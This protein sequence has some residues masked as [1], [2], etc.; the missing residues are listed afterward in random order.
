MT[1][2][3]LSTILDGKHLSDGDTIVFILTVDGMIGSGTV[4]QDFFDQ[5][6][7]NHQFYYQLQVD[8][9]ET[10]Y[11]DDDE[12]LFKNNNCINYDP[13]S[14]GDYTFVMPLNLI[15]D[16]KDYKNLQLF[17]DC[18]EGTDDNEFV[19]DSSIKYSIFPAVQKAFVFGVGKNWG[20]D[21]NTN[22]DAPDYRYE[23]NNVL[24]DASGTPLDLKGG[25]KVEVILQGKIRTYSNDAF[26]RLDDSTTFTAELYDNAYYEESSFHALSIDK[27]DGDV[28]NTA[29]VKQ[30]TIGS[31]GGLASYGAFVFSPIAEP[32]ISKTDANFKNDFR[33]QCH[34]PCNNPE[35]LLVVTDYFFTNQVTN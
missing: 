33:F 30:L 29:N 16:A 14:K 17:F 34:T 18:P 27:L 12:G 5:F 32:Y 9:W 24:R 4:E 15:Q 26:V 8:N 6:V 3:P 2:V 19:F 21:P 20:K 23:I 25:E 28:T 10:K 13:R 7:K 11:L 31:D 22:P 35:V 1:T